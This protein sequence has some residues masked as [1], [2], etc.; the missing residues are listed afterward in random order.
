MSILI[1]I[2]KAAQGCVNVSIMYPEMFLEEFIVFKEWKGRKEILN[3][4]F[5]GRP[6][7]L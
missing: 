1:Y 3:V 4:T 7:A 5:T 6:V 2:L